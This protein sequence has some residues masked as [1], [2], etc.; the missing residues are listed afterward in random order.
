MYTPFS[1]I[2]KII[3]G[4]VLCIQPYKPISTLTLLLIFTILI[5]VCLFFYQPFENQLTD[6]VC[7]SLEIVLVIYVVIVM[8]FGLNAVTGPA[9]HYLGIV[10]AAVTGL[11]AAGGLGWLVY[12]TVGAVN[13]YRKEEPVN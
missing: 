1:F 5:M 2:R 3:F 4:L 10:A 12:L 11:G 7:I 6:Y 13:K 9:A 8:L